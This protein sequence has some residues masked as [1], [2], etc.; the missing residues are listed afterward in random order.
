[1]DTSVEE[2]MRFYHVTC[3][4]SSSVD[5]VSRQ[6][7]LSLDVIEQVILLNYFPWNYLYIKSVVYKL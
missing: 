3:L 5:E 4:I 6:G 1:M 7:S 2:Q